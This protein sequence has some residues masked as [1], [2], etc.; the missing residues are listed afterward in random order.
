MTPGRE[1]LERMIRMYMRDAFDPHGQWRDEDPDTI[2]D[3]AMTT[4]SSGLGNW[5]SGAE[6]DGA[7]ETIRRSGELGLPIRLDGRG[8]WYRLTECE[9]PP[10]HETRVLAAD[11]DES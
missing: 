9:A 6:V 4:I 3:R 11:A 8:P 10:L 2:T 1:H 5:L 7:I